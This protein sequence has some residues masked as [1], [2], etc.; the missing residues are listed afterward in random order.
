MTPGDSTRG[1]SRRELDD[2]AWR[3]AERSDLPVALDI[4]NE[5]TRWLATRDIEQ[6]GSAP[7]SARELDASISDRTLF[8]ADAS[9]VVGL[10]VVD[11]KADGDFWSADE[12]DHRVSYLHHLAVARG[13]AGRQVG[14]WLIDHAADAARVAGHTR[15]RLDA[16]R[17]NTALHN[18]Y[19]S[20]GFVH[21]RT[22]YRPGRNSGALFERQL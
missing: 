22:V 15:L 13:V 16:A 4:L 9:R 10:V 17:R 7:W 14:A 21:L 8:V 11:S 12:Q 18:Y 1:G 20:Q 6:W 19:Q 2:L 5:V 3:V